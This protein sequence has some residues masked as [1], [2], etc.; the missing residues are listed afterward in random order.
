MGSLEDQLR[1]AFQVFDQDKSQGIS[2][3]E[4]F[5]CFKA[6]NTFLKKENKDEDFEA[7]F[8]EIDVNGDGEIDQEEFIAAMI[9]NP[10]FQD[11]SPF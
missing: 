10:K 6:I 2:K 11:F 4:A 3:D 8:K 9:N 5:A 7:F 1:L